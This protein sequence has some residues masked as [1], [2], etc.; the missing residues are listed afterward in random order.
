MHECLFGPG[1]MP[2]TVPGIGEDTKKVKNKISYTLPLINLSMPYLARELKSDLAFSALAFCLDEK[3]VFSF[4]DAE[5]PTFSFKML[6]KEPP[7]WLSQLSIPTSDFGSGH[8]LA[9]HELE[10]HTGLWADSAEPAWDSLSPSL[11]L[12]PSLTRAWSLPK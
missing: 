8:D 6:S 3:V 9:V 10:P 11:S 12:C 7:G 4:L 5:A 2:R 1:S